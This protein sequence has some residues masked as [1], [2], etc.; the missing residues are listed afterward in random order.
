MIYRVGQKVSRHKLLSICL[1]NIHQF[2]KKKFHW[3]ILW[4]DCNKVI[5]KYATTPLQPTVYIVCIHYR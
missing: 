1:S 3:Y 2:S 5:I 4:K